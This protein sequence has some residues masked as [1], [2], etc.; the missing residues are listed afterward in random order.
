MACDPATLIQQS[1]CYQ[2]LVTGGMLQAV[3]VVL[4]CAIRDGET[5]STDPQDLIS[6]ANCILACIPPGA[7][8]AVKL[9]ILCD[10]INA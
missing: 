7:M 5:I 9:A 2:C 4:L 8:S 1:S 6:Q 10:I 3:E